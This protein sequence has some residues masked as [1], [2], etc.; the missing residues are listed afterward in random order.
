SLSASG[1]VGSVPQT[2]TTTVDGGFNPQIFMTGSGNAFVV[3][4][5]GG[6]EGR[7]RSAAGALGTL[8]KVTSS[9]GA[10]YPLI[11]GDSSGNTVIAW[12]N[13]AHVEALARTAA[14]ALGPFHSFSIGGKGA[15]GAS[16]GV[17]SGGQAIVTWVQE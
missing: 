16:L 7:T 5:H 8:Q 14:G 1:T 6:I 10:E 4:K 13:G 15:G 12:Q 11:K 3:W 2:F 9:T 17:G